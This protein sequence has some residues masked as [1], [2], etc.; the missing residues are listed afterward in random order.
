MVKS[1]LDCGCCVVLSKVLLVFGD[2]LP[3]VLAAKEPGR[4]YLGD[5]KGWRNLQPGVA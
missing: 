4:S 2:E 1:T 5:R 3:F